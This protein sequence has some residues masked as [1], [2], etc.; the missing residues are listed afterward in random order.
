MLRSL[1]IVL[2]GY[3]FRYKS[4]LY[5]Y[6][7]YNIVALENGLNFINADILKYVFQLYA[8]KT[9][10]LKRIKALYSKKVFNSAGILTC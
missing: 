7:W 4:S 1:M 3:F 6:F 5:V 2:S 10:F 9:H 8:L